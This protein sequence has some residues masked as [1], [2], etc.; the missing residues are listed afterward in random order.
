MTGQIKTINPATAETIETYE[1]MTEQQALL[2]PFAPVTK[3]S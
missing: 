2:T 1:L 3:R